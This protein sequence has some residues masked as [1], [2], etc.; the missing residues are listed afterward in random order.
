MGSHNKFF[1]LFLINIFEVFI[2][3][4]HRNFCKVWK[5]SLK[6]V[7]LFALQSFIDRFIVYSIKDSSWKKSIFWIGHIFE[8]FWIK[9]PLFFL[10]L[11]LLFHLQSHRKYAFISSSASIFINHSIIF[12]FVCYQCLHCSMTLYNTKVFC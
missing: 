11:N 8:L 10:I 3:I 1:F 2:S 12:H 7:F 4:N 6:S 5:N 9:I